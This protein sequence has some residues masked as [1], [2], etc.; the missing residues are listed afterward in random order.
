MWTLDSPPSA[1]IVYCG[2]KEDVDSAFDNRTAAIG[3]FHSLPHFCPEENRPLQP[4]LYIT[5]VEVSEYDLRDDFVS[6]CATPRTWHN[7]FKNDTHPLV[8]YVGENVTVTCIASMYHFA[9]GTRLALKYY[10]GQT[11]FPFAM[12]PNIM[13][14]KNRNCFNYT[15]EIQIK[16]EHVDGLICENYKKQSAGSVQKVIPIQIKVPKKITFHFEPEVTEQATWKYTGQPGFILKCEAEGD[17]PPTITWKKQGRPI[18]EIITQETRGSSKC[19][20]K[21]PSLEENKRFS[22]SD[23][24]GLYTCEARNK[25]D[26]AETS[27][28]VQ[29]ANSSN[30]VVLVP[31]NE[32][33]E[34]SSTSSGSL[35]ILWIV[36]PIFAVLVL[37]VIGVLIWK[38]K[39]QSKELRLLT[40][41]E[42]DEFLFGKPEMIQHHGSSEEVNNYAPF[43][44]YNKGYEIGKE[45][46]EI[47]QNAVLGSGAYAIVLRGVLIK[48]GGERL[49]VAIKTSRTMDDISYFKALL[50]ELKIMGFIGTHPNIVNLVGAHTKNIQ[51]REIFIAIE[52]CENGNLLNYLRDNRHK[53]TNL[54]GQ[55]GE[56]DFIKSGLDSVTRE[57]FVS[58]GKDQQGLN[59]VT[60]IKW[61]YEVATGMEFLSQKKVIHGDLAARNILLN[62]HLI[63]KI[64]DFG[65]SRQLFEY[66][67]YIKK[68]QSPLPWKWLAIECL[69]DMRFSVKSDVWAYAILMYEIFSLGH[70]PYPGHSYNDE[71]LD[72]LIGGKR[73]SRPSHATNSMSVFF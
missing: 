60:L 49:K 25:V 46:L 14:D 27:F 2:R 45:Q 70:V 57:S 12:K 34:S 52:F 65:L 47:D 64:G 44:P 31:T 5:S 3:F 48:K 58:P 35:W 19:I 39:L 55:E 13:I 7:D 50:S 36:L 73:P 66:V 30:L 63:A 62:E 67:N 68:Q 28:L 43:L 56:Y 41:A 51:N 61:V 37:A 71:F 10:N 29:P 72:A 8:V 32:V 16:T 24:H 20:L 17:P 22:V 53:F 38:I 40:K 6:F 26:Y 11:E 54:V 1:G 69:Q 21:F 15:A 18:P 33:A 9:M 59:T 23:L 4:R 42:V